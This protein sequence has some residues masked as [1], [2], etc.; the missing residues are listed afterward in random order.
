[1]E[2]NVYACIDIGSYE[3]K[4][5]ICHLREERLFVLSKKTIKSIGIERGQIINFDKLVGQ[6]KKV[7]ELAELDLK[8]PLKN[9][10]LTVSPVDA[11]L[12]TAMGRI[13]LDVKQPIDSQKIRQLF[14]QVMEQPHEQTYLP[15]SLIPRIFKIDETQ[16]VQN[17]RGLS[18]MSLGIEAQRVLLP[19]TMISNLVNTVESSGFKIEEIVV[20]SISETFLTLTTPERFAKTCHI[21]VGHD[22]STLTIIN[23]GKILHA[24]TLFV[25]GH[26][27]IRSIAEKFKISEEVA[28]ELKINYGKILI[29]EADLMDNQI[30]HIDETQEEIKFITRGMLNEVITEETVKLFSMIKNHIVEDLRLKEEEY[31][32]SLAGG[33]AELPDIIYALQTKFVKQNQLPMPATIYRPTML[34]VRDSKF[35][36]LVGV[37]IFIHEL[38]LLYG[39]PVEL[40]VEVEEEALTLEEDIVLH[41]KEEEDDIGVKALSDIIPQ[42]EKVLPSSALENS[43]KPQS[44]KEAIAASMQDNGKSTSDVSIDPTKKR[45]TAATEKSDDFYSKEDIELSE[46]TDDYIDEKLGNSGVFV[47]FLDKIFNENGEEA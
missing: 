46:V 29:R 40:A 25:G 47:R 4:L 13:Y 1:M 35:S 8:Q 21:N 28:R 5:L 10:I 2:N 3:I 9:V 45:P 31:H 39:L 30:I 34:G 18:G 42:N 16:V 20:G 17:P 6:I 27:I 33:V 22:L 43:E 23:D 11:L 7:K 36:S 32:Y 19:S 15:V 14:Q 12:E 26:D 38:N 37:S 24:R 41:I 44:L